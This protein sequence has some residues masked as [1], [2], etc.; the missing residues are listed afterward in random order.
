MK[1]Q[2]TTTSHVLVIGG[3][4]GGL[5][6]ALA[7]HEAG[8]G[9]RIIEAAPEIK[10]LGTGINLLPHAVAPLARLGVLAAME[11]RAVP[12]REVCYYTQ[13][14]Q[15]VYKEPRGRFAGYELP[16]LSI[17]RADLHEVLLEA[18]RDRLGP[19]AIELDRRC[20]ALAQDEHEVLVHVQNAKGETLPEIRASIA[21]ACDGVHSVARKQMHPVEAVPRYEGTTLYRGVTRWKPFLSGASMIYLGT[22]ATGKLVLYPVRNRVDPEGRQLLNWVIEIERPDTR[23]VRDWNRTAKI[24][25]F[26]ENFQHCSYDWLD[27][28]AVLRAADS[29]FEYPMVDQEPLPFWT[30]GR[31]T[32]LGDA[33]H[34]MMPRG[35]NGA[36]HALIDAVTLANLL[37]AHRGDAR[38]ALQLYEEQRREATAKV[39]LANRE[40]SP[41]AILRVVEERTGGRPFDK[42]ED[43]LSP[44]EFEGWQERYRQ[45]AGFDKARVSSVMASTPRGSA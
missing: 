5:A 39:V 41:E 27:I 45:V 1:T 43:V 25:D 19:D 15:L 23:M 24:E 11:R 21:I 36:A 26:I 28:P 22:Q 32:L 14:G 42:I 17:H 34:P 29:I 12:T 13:L 3:G 18:V 40:I 30:Q 4:I 37:S 44:E 35:S 38:L 2:D 31:V 8:I 6:L 7:L 16:Q 33:A 9:C 10:P 20:T